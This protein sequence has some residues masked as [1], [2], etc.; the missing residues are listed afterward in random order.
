MRRRRDRID[1]EVGCL[2]IHRDVAVRVRERA[3]ND[4]DVDGKRLVAKELAAIDVEYFHQVFGR[5][6]VELAAFDARIDESAEPDVG[7]QSSAAGCDLAEELHRHAA[8]QNVGLDLL[9]TCQRLHARRPDPVPADHAAHHAFVC[10]AVHPAG[11][12]VA[13]AERMNDAE[14]A[15]M[16]FGEEPLLD[17][18]EGEGRLHQAAAAARQRDRGAVLDQRRGGLG[19]HELVDEHARGQPSGST[20]LPLPFIRLRPITM[21]WISE[22]P[23]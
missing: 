22:V 1:I 17:R 5:A 3:A 4:G 20:T 18:R 6:L 9:V 8:G 13:D 16:A 12:A 7:E 21:R 23:S 15:R 2:L 11:L 14:I 19:R 10:E